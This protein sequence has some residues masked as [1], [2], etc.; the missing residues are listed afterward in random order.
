[1]GRQVSAVIWLLAPGKTYQTRALF[2]RS[3][4]CASGQTPCSLG[5]VVCQNQ[6]CFD[7]AVFKMA[8]QEA[9]SRPSSWTKHTAVG[10]L[11]QTPRLKKHPL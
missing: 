8:H 3:S 5:S 6:G 9:S 4:L 11:T 10:V 2:G 1:M 7:A